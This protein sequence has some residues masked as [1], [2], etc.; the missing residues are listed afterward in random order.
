MRRL[1]FL[2]IAPLVGCTAVKSTYHLVEAQQ[3][4]S[5][6]E[7]RR[8]NELAVY[9]YTM[10]VRFLEKAQEEAGY[11][12]Y[13]V[14]VDLARRSA[15]WADRSIIAID[16]EGRDLDIEGMEQLPDWQLP[17]APDP[18][19]EDLSAPVPEAQGTA[20]E[21]TLWR[22]LDM[23]GEDEGQPDLLPEDE[24]ESG[25][26]PEP[27]PPP[28]PEPLITPEDTTTTTTTTT[29]TP[30]KQPEPEPAEDEEPEEDEPPSFDIPAPAPTPWDAQ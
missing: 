23:E 11:S 4:V 19:E 24:D 28:D 26:I 6:A 17:E 30:P 18:T 25:F 20:A 21:Q 8:A 22:E 16:S 7:N 27:P 15:E 2:V 14:S 12:D 9:E 10:A 29:T 1:L 13:K 3:A 5:R